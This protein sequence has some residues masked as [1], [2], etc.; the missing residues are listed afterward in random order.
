MEG[1]LISKD[2]T[3]EPTSEDKTVLSLE[4]RE[5]KVEKDEDLPDQGQSPGPNPCPRE[6]DR[7]LEEGNEGLLQKKLLGKSQPQDKEEL[8]QDKDQPP[9]EE[10][11]LIDKEEDDT[12]LMY[13][14]KDDLRD[15][16]SNKI[17]S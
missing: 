9:G 7:L 16:N 13:C 17:L 5:K 14:L 12:N 15:Q 2:L 3:L 1:A 4:S 8:L 6:E 10:R 11:L